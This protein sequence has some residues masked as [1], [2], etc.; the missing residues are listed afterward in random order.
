MCLPDIEFIIVSVSLFYL[1]REFPKIYLCMVYCHPKANVDNACSVLTD[2]IHELEKNS[3]DVPIIFTGDINECRLNASLPNFHQFVNVPKRKDRTLDLCYC[4]VTQAHRDRDW[5][6]RP[7]HAA[8]AS[9]VS[10][11]RIQIKK[12]D[13]DSVD[14]LK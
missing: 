4:K 10:T 6:L 7:L 11:K 2:H 9:P 5:Q 12:W 1:P 3:P 8:A 14:M 13:A